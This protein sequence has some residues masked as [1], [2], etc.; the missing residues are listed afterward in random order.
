LRFGDTQMQ[1]LRTSAKI[2]PKQL[3]TRLPL[4]PWRMFLRDSTTSRLVL[5]GCAAALLI[6]V[7]CGGASLRN[8][9]YED[10]DVR[11]RVG[12][13]AADW[14]P[15]QVSD[16]D[17]AFSGAQLGT[18]SVNSTCVD[19]EDVP[20]DALINHLLFEMTNRRFV[21]EETVTLDGRGARHVIVQAELDGVPLEIE[22][23]VLK[24][25]GCV[26]DLDHI[27]SRF[28]SPTARAAFL[29]FVQHFAV[30]EVHIDG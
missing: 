25:D 7:G 14:R 17:L 18:V 13:P 26:F 29:H 1:I 27:R 28:A 10:E 6:A 21:L 5:A 24:K 4:G 16:N 8:G 20:A 19:Y 9:I 3:G 22:L 23:F 11:Y 15:L 2:P 30:L 12:T